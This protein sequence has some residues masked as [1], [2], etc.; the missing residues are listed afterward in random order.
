MHADLATLEVIAMKLVDVGVVDKHAL[1]RT[2]GDAV[3]GN[4]GFI[5]KVKK[6][7]PVPVANRTIAHYFQGGGIHQG[8]ANV[9]VVGDIVA[10][11]AGVS[12]HIVNCKAQLGQLIANKRV[13]TTGGDKNTVAAEAHLVILDN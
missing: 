3:T 2:A 11:G 7:S 4:L 1:L 13:V 9:V 6:Y 10:D 8:I 5:G 12:V